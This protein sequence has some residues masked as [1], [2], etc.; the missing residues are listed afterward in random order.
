MNRRPE[1]DQLLDEPEL[2]VAIAGGTYR[3][4]E[5]P[6]AQLARLQAYLR[7]TVPHPVEAIKPHLAGLPDRQADELLRLAY[8]EGR[9]WPPQAGTGAGVAALM[10]TPEGQVEALTAAL[11]V[12][13]PGLPSCEVER[14]Y[15]ALQRD[16]TARA[17][18]ARKAGRAY[19][20]EGLVKRIFGV[21]F[22]LGDPEHEH[23]HA[24]GAGA[25]SGPVPEACAPADA[26]HASTGA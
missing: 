26:A 13:H 16:A 3:F 10:R 19:G 7:R 9:D 15:R 21:A 14:L 5:L 2:V 20:G 4:A 22:G 12:F 11:S 24:D 25:G 6:L 17:R 1:L 23:E 18:A 8:E